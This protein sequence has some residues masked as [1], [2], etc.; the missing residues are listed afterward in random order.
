M[1]RIRPAA[2][3][4]LFY[5]GQAEA[6]RRMVLQLLTD[7]PV[8][9]ELPDNARALIVPHAGLVYSGPIA[10]RAY[11][12]L[13]ACLAKGHRWRRVLMLG[14]NHRVPL[15]GIAAPDAEIF[16]MPNGSVSID[17]RAL[18]E[19]ERRFDIQ[20]R[21]DVHQYE[22]CLEVQLPFLQELL[23]GVKLIPLV[24]GQ[25][26][27]E[28]VADLVDWAWAQSDTLVLVS[29]DLSH[30][31]SY[32]EARLIDGETDDELQTLRADIRPDQACGA[33]ALNGLMLAARRKGLKVERL[34]L[35]NS[36]D[37]AGG[38]DQVVGYGSYVLY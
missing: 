11:N 2:V 3:A 15:H 38:Q 37:T 16:E 23:P 18:A 30:Y 32:A 31:H 8:S 25:V 22:H 24:V 21:P 20:I 12:L 29:S 10:A 7:N 28:A 17:T 34:D 35:R 14:P 9:G 33:Y 5:P 1:S 13:K 27:A 26:S 4:G 19:L 36:G 6:L